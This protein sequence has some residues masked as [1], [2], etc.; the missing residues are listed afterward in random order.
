MILTSFDA[1]AVQ[2]LLGS[3]EIHLISLRRAVAYTA[4]YPFLSKLVLPA[5]AVDFARN[6]P[7]DD[8]E[9][10]A[11]KT[12]LAVRRDLPPAVQYLLLDAATDIHSPPA[13]FHNASQF[14]AAEAI[15]LPL[16][17]NARR[18]YKSGMPFLQHYLPLW[19]AVLTEQLFILLIPMAAVAYPL[20]RA[21]P[22]VYGWGVRRRIHRLYGE[23]KMLEIE[24]ED[25]PDE[26]RSRVLLAELSRLEGRVARLWVPDSFAHMAYTLRRN[27]QLVR[28]RVAAHDTERSQV[29][30]KRAGVD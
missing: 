10:I 25:H 29:T 19:L 24:F 9:M 20:I 21:L 30:V 13:L 3:P 15:D 4:L 27:L 14:P 23:L 1:P 26:Q 7:P 17:E 6:R 2:R 22:A 28:R 16:G 5:G 8:V 11:T 18:Y 12:S